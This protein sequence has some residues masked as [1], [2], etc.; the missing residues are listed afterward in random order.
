MYLPT[1]MPSTKFRFLT[2]ISS[3]SPTAETYLQGQKNTASARA[4]L[5]YPPLQHRC[6]LT[7]PQPPVPAMLQIVPTQRNPRQAG[8]LP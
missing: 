1:E 2:A 4:V 8:R 6:S 5:M 7:R 3:A